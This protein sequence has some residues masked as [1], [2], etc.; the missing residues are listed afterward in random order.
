MEDITMC[1]FPF[2]QVQLFG[3]GGG[4]ILPW[5]SCSH[6]EQGASPYGSCVTGLTSAL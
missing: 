5:Y 3:G 6:V 4:T 1:R 2:T